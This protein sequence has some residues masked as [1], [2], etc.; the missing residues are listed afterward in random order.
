M[1]VGAAGIE[2]G[3]RYENIPG[4]RFLQPACRL[5]HFLRVE[6][7]QG[8][9]LDEGIGAV[10][11]IEAAP[12]LGLKIQHP[13][14]FQVKRHMGQTWVEPSRDLVGPRR[15]HNRRGALR[16]DAGYRRHIFAALQRIQQQR[17][18]FPFADDSVIGAQ[19]THHRLCEDGKTAPA[20]NQRDSGLRADGIDQVLVF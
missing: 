16:D 3:V 8:P 4:S 6:Q 19:F 9:S 18:P 17:Q 15:R 12:P 10:D 11:A 2:G 13:S 7:P 5:A 20:K 14:P 1:A